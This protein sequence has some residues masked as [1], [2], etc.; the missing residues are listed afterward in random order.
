[1]LFPLIGARLHGW[2]D[3]LVV[4][5]YLAGA[6]ALGLRGGALAIAIGGAIVHF[7]LTRF[8]N[9]P[10]G[11]FKLIPFRVHAFIELGE[12]LAVLAATLAVAGDRPLPQR[13][14]LG[15]MGAAQLGAFALSDYRSPPPPTRPPAAATT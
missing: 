14:F 11:T 4:L 2:L 13:L 15:L 7:A 3:D 9:Y 6:F 10:Q 12:G 1:M 8:T 5:I